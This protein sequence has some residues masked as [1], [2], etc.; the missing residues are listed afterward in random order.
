MKDVILFDF[1][2]IGSWV[3]EMTADEFENAFV[4]LCSRFGINAVAA[5]DRDKCIEILVERDCM[6]HD[7]AVE[8]FDCNVI[9]SWVGETT[10]VFTLLWNEW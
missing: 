10:P 6:D 8:Y 3:G 1:N 9:G 2:V 4:G 5:Y 7:E